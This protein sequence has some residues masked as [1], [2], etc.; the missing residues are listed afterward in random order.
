[1]QTS[2][3]LSTDEITMLQHGEP[4]RLRA[5]DGHEVVLVLAEQYGQ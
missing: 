3:E 2:I 5:G 4:L 1:M